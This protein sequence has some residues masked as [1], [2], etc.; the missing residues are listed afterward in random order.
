MRQA[1]VKVQSQYLNNLHLDL[2]SVITTHQYKHIRKT[3]MLT[4]Y[5]KEKAYAGRRVWEASDR[6]WR[7]FSASHHDVGKQAKWLVYGDSN[8]FMQSLGCLLV[9]GCFVFSN[10]LLSLMMVWCVCIA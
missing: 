3:V 2:V 9:F 10:F 8:G 5:R 1:V 7:P 6:P 4:E